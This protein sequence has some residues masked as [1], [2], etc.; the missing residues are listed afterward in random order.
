M[1]TKTK[2][3]KATAKPADKLSKVAAAA[4]QKAK[5]K[6]KKVEREEDDGED[7]QGGKSVV[8]AKYKARYGK[9]QHCGDD[10]AVRLKKHLT[11]EDGKLDM[12]KLE[13]FGR[14]NECWK[15]EWASL[16]PG[17]RRMLMGVMLRKRIRQGEKVVWR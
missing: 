12:T 9:E 15:E 6:T 16:N 17:Q 2:S 13:R 14:A 1:A 10:T 11:G 3:T 8:P 5:A 7:E 4:K